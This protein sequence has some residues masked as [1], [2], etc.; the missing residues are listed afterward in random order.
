METSRKEK[1]IISDA[2]QL[3]IKNGCNWYAYIAEHNVCP[4]NK[5]AIV[6]VRMLSQSHKVRL[7]VNRA[8][9]PNQAINLKLLLQSYP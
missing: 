3:T 9:K 5:I 1:G 8:L 4:M 2:R 6:D 7:E